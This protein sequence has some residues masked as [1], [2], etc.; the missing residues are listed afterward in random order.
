MPVTGDDIAA[1]TVR[2]ARG[3]PERF[4]AVHLGLG[5][6]GHTASWPPVPHPG[7]AVVHSDNA[8]AV[9]GNF[10]GHARMTLTPG[11]VNHARCRLLLT[12][13][14]GKAEMVRRWID[15]DASIPVTRVRRSAT[16]VFLDRGAASQLPR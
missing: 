15:R 13:G 14:P 8:V 2:Y 9:I 3:L 11:P 4:D 5:E 7:A 12:T 6:D 10:N 1:A 16:T